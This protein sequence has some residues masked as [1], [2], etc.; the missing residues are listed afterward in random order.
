MRQG[1]KVENRK[2][3]IYFL[4]SDFTF[5][6]RSIITMFLHE[7]LKTLPEGSVSQINFLT[8]I[9]ILWHKK[10]LRPNSKF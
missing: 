2:F 7:A 6:N 8:I 3:N 1:M 9:Y 4:N 10:K 5:N